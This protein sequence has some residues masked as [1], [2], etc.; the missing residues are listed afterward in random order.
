MNKANVTAWQLAKHMQF[1]E[2]AQL[3]HH[4]QKV[5]IK[6]RIS[7]QTCA[8]D[9]TGWLRVCES[10][11]LPPSRVDLF[12]PNFRAR[13]VVILINGHETTCTQA[14][15]RMP[16]LRSLRNRGMHMT[17]RAVLESSVHAPSENQRTHVIN[18]IF[19]LHHLMR[20]F[21][22]PYGRYCTC[23]SNRQRSTCFLFL[24]ATFS[25]SHALMSP[26]PTPCRRSYWYKIGFRSR[27]MFSH[28]CLTHSALM[29][30]HARDHT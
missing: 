27:H 10:N 2:I 12:R 24:H 16:C 19:I 28:A 26:S 11:M 8:N 21:S 23:T 25:L 6:V 14:A 30:S 17:T 4:E 29:K 1:N 18:N 22:H 3:L 7:E 20:E 15:F 9:V 13:T 5:E